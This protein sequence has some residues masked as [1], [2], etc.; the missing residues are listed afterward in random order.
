M[1]NKTALVTGA[2]SGIGEVFAREL[3]RQ[4]YTVTCVARSGDKLQKLVKELGEGH[5]VLTADLS[6]S[7]DLQRVADDLEK[8]HYSLLVNNAGYGVWLKH[9]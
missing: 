6:N 2:S 3:S 5:R 4:G 7:N 9:R 1:T 8:N